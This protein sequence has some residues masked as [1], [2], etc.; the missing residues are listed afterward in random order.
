MLAAS[1]LSGGTGA[2]NSY[3][4]RKATLIG[5]GYRA[6]LQQ[7]AL[8]QAAAAGSTPAYGATLTSP[9]PNAVVGSSSPGGSLN[10]AP[11]ALVAAAASGRR[12]GQTAQVAANDIPCETCHSGQSPPLPFPPDTS[13]PP[14]SLPR[15]PSPPP[16]M[17]TSLLPPP[18][19]QILSAGSLAGLL[20]DPNAV[21]TR[22]R[23]EP[24]KQCDVQWNQDEVTCDEIDPSDVNSRRCCHESANERRAYCVKTDGEVGWPLLKTWWSE[25]DESCH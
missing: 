14:V 3:D 6:F 5:S 18:L 8:Q 17:A 22:R 23:R 10:W 19:A 16:G 9:A 2:Y 4:P 12:L 20:G 11:S 1:P 25:D 13:L 24:R 15:T 7:R 21:Q